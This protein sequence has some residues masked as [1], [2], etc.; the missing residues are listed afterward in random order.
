MVF[1]V[2]TENVPRDARMLRMH[3]QGISLRRIAEIEGVST[4]AVSAALKAY[5]AREGETADKG[6][7]DTM[8]RR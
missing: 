6:G 8:M 5:R 1:K 2:K 7:D 4:S 3:C